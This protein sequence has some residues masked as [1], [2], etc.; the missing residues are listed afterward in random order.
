MF[1]PSRS[2]GLDTL[3]IIIGFMIDWLT[4]MPCEDLL[5]GM[6]NASGVS[7]RLG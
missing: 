4:S 1:Q 6:L 7:D 2:H 3:D 5:D